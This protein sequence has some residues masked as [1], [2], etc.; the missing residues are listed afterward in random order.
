MTQS[1][2]A[3]RL[4]LGR[5]LF[6]GVRIL[7]MRSCGRR[8]PSSQSSSEG[9]VFIVMKEKKQ[10]VFILGSKGIPASYGGFETFADELVKMQKSENIF[11]HVACLKEPAPSQNYDHVDRVWVKTPPVGPATAVL[12]DL[13]ALRQ[14][15]RWCRNHPEAEKP[16]FYILA[17]RIGPFMAYFARQIHRLGG[18]LFINPDG[19]EWKRAKWNKIIRRYWKMSE[20]LM[21]KQ[22]DLIICDNQAI[23][24]Y[25]Q[26]EYPGLDPKT[27]FI[28]YG[29]YLDKVGHTEKRKQAYEQ[30]LNEHQLERFG[31]YLIVGRF[32]PENNYETIIREHMASNTKRKLAI[33]CTEN[34]KLFRELDE[35]L[36]F[37]KD[38]RILFIGT[39]YNQDLLMEIR[40]GAYA[41]YHGHEVGGTNPSLLE[42]LA[43]TD[44]NLVLDVAFNKEVAGDAGIYWTKE[45]GNLRAVIE[46]TEKLTEE[47]RASYSQK[48]KKRIKDCY[49]WPSIVQQY[50]QI[51]EERGR[52][53]G[54]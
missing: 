36:Q 21:V 44:V 13:L 24:K 54:T 53:T 45:N 18:S 15:L 5:S 32:V 35:K 48:A 16:V 27:M 10:H 11:Y 12:Y 31:Y 42:A 14:C 20:K 1:R 28:P 2:K 7:L 50:E 26:N 41:Y 25:I 43:K 38:D 40:E 52:K 4:F 9:W 19:H 3:L 17:C 23:Q 51:F 49:S 22:A 8:H 37:S 33:I 39:E 34:E 6:P 29:A 47:E 46:H 30:W